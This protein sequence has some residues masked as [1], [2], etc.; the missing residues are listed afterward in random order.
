MLRSFSRCALV[1]MIVPPV[2]IALL[3][4]NVAQVRA[5]DARKLQNP[6]E[7]PAETLKT[8]DG[9]DLSLNAARGRSATVLV[10]LSVECPISGEFLPAIQELADAYRPRGVRLIAI[11][12]N[13]GETLAAMADYA[14]QHQL[15]FPFVKDEGGKIAR[16]MLFNV[17][18]EVRLFDA[19][20]KVVYRGRIDDRYRAGGGADRAKATPDLARALDEVLAGKPV[21]QARTRPVGCP[22]Q[23]SAPTGG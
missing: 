15:A 3:A 8:S 21:S 2:A 23:L 10:T 17:T 4:V 9:C 13:G 22:I 18:P 6:D 11:N 19:A 7:F 1:A 20:G 5:V 16:R 12:P 14:R